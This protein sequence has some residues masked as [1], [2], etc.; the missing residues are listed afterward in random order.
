PEGE[1]TAATSGNASPPATDLSARAEQ[2]SAPAPTTS[3]AT[4]RTTTAPPAAGTAGQADQNTART[5]TNARSRS[6]R[7]GQLP[8]T[9]S[10][11]AL[12]ELLSGL[13]I[14]GAFGI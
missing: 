7:R 4:T 8:R 14:A 10:E 9:G 2:S 6:G 5:D 12:L 11:L 13:S 1:S 3:G